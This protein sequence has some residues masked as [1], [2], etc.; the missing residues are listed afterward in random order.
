MEEQRQ[1]IMVVSND[2]KRRNTLGRL[3]QA[4]IPESGIVEVDH[5][6]A[7]KVFTAILPECV[8]ICEYDEA[9]KG[10]SGW[11]AG[12][13]TYHTLKKHAEGHGVRILKLGHKI[14]EDDPDYLTLPVNLEEF[15]DKIRKIDRYKKG[16]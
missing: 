4:F 12:K 16:K 10:M 3:I 13:P 1:N 9:G 11:N 2:R 8:I 7:L 15:I 6:K 5:S 14:I